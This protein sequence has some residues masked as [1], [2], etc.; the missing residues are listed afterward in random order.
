MTPLAWLTIAGF[1]MATIALVG[2]ATLLLSE[3][4]LRRLL[5]PLVAFASGALLGGA[6]FHLLPAALDVLPGYDRVF[7]WTAVGFTSFLLLEQF[8]NLYHG[9][10]PRTIRPRA[11]LILVADG[12]HNYVGGLAVGGAFLV[13]VRLGWTAWLVAAAHEVPQE[14][15]DFGVLVQGGFPPRR[16]LSFNFLSGLT[17]LAGSL[18]AWAAA[19]VGDVG[20]LLP[21]AAG[22][23]TYIAAV[24]LVPEITPQRNLRTS[25][26]HFAAFAVGL[27]LLAA[28]RLAE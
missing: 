2:S 26:L 24:D 11:W 21:L 22:N 20:F 17:F 6:W 4:T 8:L 9:R 14:L 15:G 7:L 5:L 3:Q 19:F 10:H 12:V 25:L 13:D 18:T 28:L 23:F 1:A 27:G 16:A